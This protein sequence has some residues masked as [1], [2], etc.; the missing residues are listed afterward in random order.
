MF[1]TSYFDRLQD[2]LASGCND[3]LEDDELQYY[4]AL[5]AMIGLNRKYG[6]DTAISFLRKEPFQ[7]PL[8][9]AREMYQEA[10]NLFYA[11]DT[12]ENAAHR[13]L[14]Y[15]ELNKAALVVLKTARNSKDIE[16]YGNIK[17]Q[18][19]KIKQL[20]RPDE[21][22]IEL[23][24]AKPL[25]LYALDSKAV[26]LESVDRNIL[27]AQI[28]AIPDINENERKRL[29]REARIVDIDIIEMIDDTENKTKNL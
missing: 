15:E 23:P 12:I 29:K 24:K 4:N 10:I 2:Y 22:K 28:D 8:K 11:D 9:R 27:A 5:Y 19:F 20:D 26:G 17:M 25:K 7:L 18:A 13:N 14:L 16:I 1:E 6:K 21:K 3:E